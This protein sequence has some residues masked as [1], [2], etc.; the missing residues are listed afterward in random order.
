MFYLLISQVFPCSISL[1]STRLGLAEGSTAWIPP[2]TT[3]CPDMSADL[4]GPNADELTLG[5]E[6]GQVVLS[7]DG[8]LQAVVAV[9]IIDDDGVSFHVVCETDDCWAEGDIGHKGLLI[10]VRLG[11]PHPEKVSL[12]FH[13]EDMQA[14]GDTDYVPAQGCLSL[15]PGVQSKRFQVD[16]RGDEDIEGDESFLVVFEDLQGSVYNASERLEVWILDDE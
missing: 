16:V 4:S 8:V 10:E 11:R 12:Q 2:T 5:D 13:T 3:N 14:S 9:E 7:R 15:D 1:G 6:T